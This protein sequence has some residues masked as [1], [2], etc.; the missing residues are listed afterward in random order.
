VSYPEVNNV[1]VR[2]IG[3]TPSP[4]R[5][6]RIDP[7]ENQLFAVL[8]GAAELPAELPPDPAELPPELE[9]LDESDDPDEL[10]AGAALSPDFAPSPPFAPS[11]FALSPDFASPLLLAGGFADEYRS[12]YHPPPLN[13]IA[14][15]VSVRSIRPPQ[16]GHSVSGA[17][18]NFWIFSVRRRHSWHSYS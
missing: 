14:G 10:A 15:A 5:H 17:S 2:N 9:E 12:L 6:T 3:C 11:P 7:L 1:T 4:A 8:A 13:W 16:C 18:A